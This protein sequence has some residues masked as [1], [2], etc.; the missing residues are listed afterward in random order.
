[1]DKPFL[2]TLNLY[3]SKSAL[4]ISPSPELALVFVSLAS[5]IPGME[6]RM[7][8]K[9]TKK[10]LWDKKLTAS[11][12]FEGALEVAAAASALAKGKES[13][14]ADSKGT[15]PSWYRDPA[16]CGRDGNAKIIGFY[17]PK[18]P[19]NS[20]KVRYFLGITENNKSKDG[21]KIGIALEYPDLFKISRV[22]EEAALAILG[23]RKQIEARCDA[24]GHASPGT[25][26]PHTSDTPAANAQSTAM[27][28]GTSQPSEVF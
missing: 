18:D 13:L 23:W 11:F 16:K 8:D 15:L 20:S 27:A 22:M 7:P 17:R 4:Q 25:S 9:N 14:V 28:N 3:R 26:D 10:Y 21:Q 5:V 19:P 2:Q 1:M 12:N 24:N 6:N